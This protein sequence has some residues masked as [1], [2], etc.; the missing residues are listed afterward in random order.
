MVSF[1]SALLVLG[2]ATFWLD[3]IYR[4][5]GYKGDFFQNYSTVH[6]SSERL[7]RNDG[8]KKRHNLPGW[9]PS[10]KTASHVFNVIPEKRLL[11]HTVSGNDASPMYGL[12]EW[13]QGKQK[14]R[15]SE[16]PRCVLSQLTTVEL[17]FGISLS[18][19]LLIERTGRTCSATSTGGASIVFDPLTRKQIYEVPFPVEHIF[20]H[21]QYQVPIFK[22]APHLV[23]KFIL[24]VKATVF[25]VLQKIEQRL[26]THL[27]RSQT[28]EQNYPSTSA[29]NR[30]PVLCGAYVTALDTHPLKRVLFYFALRH[31]IN[32][33]NCSSQLQFFTSPLL[34]KPINGVQKTVGDVFGAFPSM[35]KQ[36]NFVRLPKTLSERLKVDLSPVV[37]VGTDSTSY[38][39]PVT[40]SRR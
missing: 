2:S 15:S 4:A 25:H 31:S 5:V 20:S 8:I 29:N 10:N 16:E 17:Y 24:D 28:T 35:L 7:I 32:T 38:V 37:M 39:D 34:C 19:W 18:F 40:D 22:K 6:F 1:R 14:K 30:V 33:F 27:E 36:Y 3:S 11:K 21:A 23:K 26:L 9:P 13:K 12:A